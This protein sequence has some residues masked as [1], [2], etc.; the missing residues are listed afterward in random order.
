VRQLKRLLRNKFKE[1]APDK[2]KWLKT[3][4]KTWL[5]SIIRINEATKTVTPHSRLSV[6][7]SSVQ[8]RELLMTKVPNNV[9]RRPLLKQNPQYKQ[10]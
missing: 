5:M 3:N 7:K 2:Q 4:Y 10:K 1:A 9:T 8:H 6:C